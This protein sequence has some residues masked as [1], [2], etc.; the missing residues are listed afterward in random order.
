MSRKKS[1]KRALVTS[2]LSLLL[3]MIM[4]IGTTF[5]W[6][7]DEV[8]STGNKIQSGSLVVDLEV[9]ATDNQTWASV[10]ESKEPLFN[11][12]KWEPRYA[13]F[14]ILK[15]QNEGTL[16]FQWYAEMVSAEELSELANV[17]DVYIKEDAVQYPLDS[18][19]NVVQYPENSE[20]EADGWTRVGTLA[21]FADS[22]K[23]KTA[24]IL[25]VGENNEKLL[26]IALK[27]HDSVE[28]KYQGMELGAF[29]INIVATQFTAED[30]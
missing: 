22:I 1:I 11:Y 25:E 30:I 15:V 16:P 13:E 4:L 5:A 26:G 7:A 12:D 6:F 24:G 21:E 3:C 9:L 18:E 2:V 14:K 28:S 23:E 8:T 17:I 27:M 19:H 10:K 20:L 29:D